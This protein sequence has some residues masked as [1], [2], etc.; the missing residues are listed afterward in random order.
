MQAVSDSIRSLLERAVHLARN[1]VYI[2]A[3]LPERLRDSLGDDLPVEG[4]ELS[5]REEDLQEMLEARLA[6]IGLLS[7]ASIYS[8]PGDVCRNPDGR[9]VE[10]AGLSPRRLVCLGNEM[11][12]RVKAPPLKPE[13]LP[14]GGD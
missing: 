11:L 8:D 9:L 3:F 10:V 13:H 14:G 12:A 2:K 5:W 7:L 1:G 6:Y 4:V